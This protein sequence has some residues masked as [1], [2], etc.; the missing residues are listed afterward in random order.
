MSRHFAFLFT[1][2]FLMGC[3]IKPHLPDRIDDGLKTATAASQG[4]D[5]FMLAKAAKNVWEPKIDPITPG[6]QKMKKYTGIDSILVAKNNHLVFEA[7]FNGSSIDKPH[8]IAS[9]GK[10]IISAM[11]GVAVNQG[12]LADS[13][14]SLHSL[15]PYRDINGWNEQKQ[16]I[17]LQHLLTMQTGWKC[18]YGNEDM[19]NC[20]VEM[21]KHEDPYKWVLD[22]PLANP[23]GT[24][25]QYNEA[26]PKFLIASLA[27]ATKI[28]PIKYFADQFMAPMQISSNIFLNNSLTS[29]DMM[30][31]GLLYANKGKFNGNQLLSKE[32]ISEST[33]A[34][35]TFKQQAR[36][37]ISGYG[38]FWWLR[39]FSVAGKNYEGFYA[40]GNG[41]QYIIV[42]PSLDLVAVF[43]GRNFNSM[44]YMQQPFDIMTRYIIPSLLDL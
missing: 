27:L 36:S 43:T 38:Y 4:I 42:L 3:E 9:L 23:P 22:L 5:G 39:S 37:K 40:A 44:H 2:T 35:V 17:N 18:G 41:G 1:L 21:E 24:A 13:Q 19:V 14:Q 16:S 32:W 30:K 33:S 6:I 11:V 12:Y 26:S 25:F 10:S 31:F 28:D 29:R 15:M 8:I 20:G 7:Y 34:H